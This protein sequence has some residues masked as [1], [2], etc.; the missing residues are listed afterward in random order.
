MDYTRV[1]PKKLIAAVEKAADHLEQAEKALKPYLAIL[2]DAERTTTPRAP[3][4]FPDAGRTLA[5]AAAKHPEVAAVADFDS[6]A[7]NEDLDN[8]AALAPIL[9]KLEHLSSLVNDTR[10]TWLSEAWVPSLALY[11]VAKVKAKTDGALRAV[12]EPLAAVF[13]TRRS[14][15]KKPEDG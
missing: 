14:R 9:E 7:V 13:A 3:N 4:A 8:A 1:D 11:A 12:V 6:E 2:T 15:G 10:L 5:R